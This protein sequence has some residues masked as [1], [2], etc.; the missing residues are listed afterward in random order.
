MH[1]TTEKENS[2]YSSFCDVFLNGMMYHNKL[3]AA[4]NRGSVE[5]LYKAARGALLECKKPVA[6][7]SRIYTSLKATTT[8]T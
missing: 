8:L 2:K 1:L 3:A 6:F 7:Y 5:K 4:F